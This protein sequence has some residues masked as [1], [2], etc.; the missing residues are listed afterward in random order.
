VQTWDDYW[1]R[2][3]DQVKENVPLDEVIEEYGISLRNR[4]GEVQFPCPLHGDGKDKSWSARYYPQSSSTH[5]FACKETRDVIDWVMDYEERRR[6]NAL[7][8]SEAIRKLER[9]YDIDPP[10]SPEEY[11]S[12]SE[13]ESSTDPALER[14]FQSLQETLNMDEGIDRGGTF[15]DIDVE[16][17]NIVSDHREVEDLMEPLLKIAS[18][19]DKVRYQRQSDEIDPKEADQLIEKSRRKLQSLVRDV[20]AGNI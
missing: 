3:V 16:M 14:Q 18:I 5:C 7:K 15:D 10:P 8:F 17:S 9:A 20:K 13:D 12:T 11:P 19:V 6:G 4:N 1:D 2:R